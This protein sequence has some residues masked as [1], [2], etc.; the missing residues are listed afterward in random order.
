MKKQIAYKPVLL[1]FILFVIS[2]FVRLP[3]LLDRPLANH[4]E[5]ATS[6]VLVTLKS[7]EEHSI[8][9]HKFLPIFTRGGEA[10]ANID[11][12]PTAARSDGRGNW[13]YTSFPPLSFAVP[14]WGIKLFGGSIEP[15]TLRIF[16][17]ILHLISAYLLY[18]IVSQCFQERNSDKIPL[19]ILSPAIVAVTVYL[20]SAEPL[21][22]HSNAYW[23][24]SLAQPIW[25][26]VIFITLKI[27]KIQNTCP[28]INFKLLIY[29]GLFLFLLCY[30]D[31]I[32]YVVS[33]SIFL[34]S[35]TS[36][37][38][39]IFS[40]TRT[41]NKKIKGFLRLCAVTLAIPIISSIVMITHFS[42]VIGVR[43]YIEALFF[44]FTYR[45]NSDS[46]FL[47]GLLENYILG[48]GAFL[49][50]IL[51]F[52]FFLTF[53]TNNLI[54]FKKQQ[55]D[56]EQSKQLIQKQLFLLVWLASFPIIENFLL[57]QHAASYTFAT[58]KVSV[59][60]SIIVGILYYKLQFF[61]KK[62]FL[63]II[64]T[65][66]VVLSVSTY[67]WVNK[68]SIIRESTDLQLYGEQA[69]D[70]IRHTVSKEEIAFIDTPVR[71]HLIYYAGRNI[72]ESCAKADCIKEFLLTTSFRKA[73]IYLTGSNTGST[74]EFYEWI[75]YGEPISY[76]EAELTENQDIFVK[77]LTFKAAKH[78]DE[79][80]ENGISRNGSG[81]FVQDQRLLSL[82][83]PGMELSFNASGKHKIDKVSGDQI[84]LSGNKLD[85]LS[86]G[87]PY[88]IKAV[89][90]SRFPEF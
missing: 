80:W 26:L 83:K 2:V 36:L 17:L 70:L 16:N 14:F 56:R 89:I 72:V 63:N 29:L 45:S 47:R 65:L 42:S 69:G 53:H 82:L 51:I 34:Y 7:F 35:L 55:K 88:Y 4:N 76:L 84:W 71:G 5:D 77:S 37:L 10:S 66:M 75:Q 48:Y 32:G 67:Y 44:R 43:E 39:N 19:G 24:L 12:L 46:N 3:N 57:L 28:P 52:V 25:L 61:Y 78:Q 22:S 21:W 9:E 40:K 60:I 13:F 64:V 59:L 86:D 87:Y 18:S 81:F 11:N 73:K 90:H 79:N 1:I 49:F 50:C 27:N 68:P 74:S 58:L 15:L 62:R 20:F 23:S 54:K 6:H 31:W 85:P 41:S 30:T 8:S 38:F 33:V